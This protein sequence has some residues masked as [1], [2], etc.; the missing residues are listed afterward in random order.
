MKRRKY[1]TRNPNRKIE[2]LE[3]GLKLSEKITYPLVTYSSLA[4]Y[5]KLSTQLIGHYFKSNLNLQ[6]EL[7]GYAIEKEYLPLIAQGIAA[8]DAFVLKNAPMSLKIKAVRFI[9]NSI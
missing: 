2:I 8:N 5:S 7:I 3:K 6:K 9:Q 1:L 4:E